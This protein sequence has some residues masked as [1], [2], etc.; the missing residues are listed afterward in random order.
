MAVPGTMGTTA[1]AV[2]GPVTL[3]AARIASAMEA[4][5]V[6]RIA[7]FDSKRQ[8]LHAES[9]TSIWRN[10]LQLANSGERFARRKARARRTYE[11][12]GAGRPSAFDPKLQ[13]EPLVGVVQYS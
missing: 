11:G 4:T 13:L 7:R 5:L 10:V 2:A 12:P 9:A 6:L 8:S 1:V 3:V